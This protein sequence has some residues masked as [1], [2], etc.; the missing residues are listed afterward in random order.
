[1]LNPSKPIIV[2]LSGGAD[3]MA[4][5][6][7]LLARVPKHLI[8]IAHVDHCWRSSSEKEAACLA[9]Y[10][11]RLGLPFHLHRL[12][13]AP[14]ANKEAHAR[15]HRHRFFR[16][17]FFHLKAEAVVLAH[18]GD[19][20]VE[21]ILKRF[22]E[23][24][25]LPNLGTMQPVSEIDGVTYWRPLLEFSK[26]ELRPSGFHFDDPT[27]EDTRFLRARMRQQMLPNLEKQFGKRMQ[28]SILRLADDAVRINNYL[29]HQIEPL[30]QRVLCS[31]LGLA[32]ELPEGLHAVELEHCVRKLLKQ[33][34]TPILRGC[35]DQLYTIVGKANKRVMFGHRPVHVDRRVIF[36]PAEHRLNSR[37]EVT[38]ESSEAKSVQTGWKAV[39]KGEA[40]MMLPQ[41]D[42]TVMEPR[43]APPGV[44]RQWTARR[45]PAFLR[46]NVPLVAAKGVVVGD[47]FVGASSKMRGSGVQVHLR[48]KR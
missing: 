30:M 24:S 8:H 42:Y 11:K 21:T 47:F 7:W 32:I 29:D 31:S 44:R 23:G 25:Y 10:A 14:D 22:F 19:D 41:G 43:D 36:F 48:I 37:W 13:A 3:S 33:T 2:G 1:M 40:T 28:K 46:E 26:S 18:H 45:I 34:G 12:G 27:N 6:D 20:R 39:W 15:E 5:L 9:N 17:L 38:F 4:L 16:K 35:L